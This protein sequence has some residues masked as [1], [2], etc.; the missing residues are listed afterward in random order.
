MIGG[1]LIFFVYTFSN[2]QK[3]VP[4]RWACI[5]NSITQGVGASR[6]YPGTLQ[7]FLGPA[8][9][10]QNFGV[11]ARTL[12]RKGDYSYWTQ[13]KLSEVFNF[14]PNM[15][16]IKLGTNDSKPV[17]WD[18]HKGEFEKNLSEFVDTLTSMPSKPVIWLVLPTPSFTDGTNSGDI[19]GTV[20]KNEIIPI[21]K[22]VATA[23][24]LK[25]IDVN[26]PLLNHP[27][28]FPDKVHPSDEGQD[29]IAAIFYRSFLANVTRVAC[30]GNS[31]TEYAWNG[32][33]LDAR[34]AYSIKLNELLGANY[35]V[36]NDGRSGAFMMKNG[37]SPY[38]NTG[39][40]DRALKLKPNIVTIKLGTNDSRPQNWNKNQYLADYRTMV[41]TLNKWSSKP[42]I[43]LCLPCPAWKRNGGWPFDG[44]NDSLMLAQVI[45]SIK[46]IAQEKTLDFIDLRT[47]ML[48]LESLVTD[49]VHPNAEGQDSIAHF[50]YRAF[51]KG[52]IS[53]AH[54]AANQKKPTTKNMRQLLQPNFIGLRSSDEILDHFSAQGRQLNMS[55]SQ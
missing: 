5:G 38:W 50:I 3:A 34:D 46:Q 19:R 37:P 30:I 52:P 55:I 45:P 42:K 21:I 27:E 35:W 41:D 13:G 11:S 43:F 39:L 8:F 54:Q 22:K 18:A 44:I 26:T 4:I 24:N 16:T 36:E 2:A 15:V 10:V 31:I 33:G 6:P 20:I 29:S 14:K 17:N 32:N 12:L 49:G 25:V 40:L 48:P 23:K 1:F 28:L 51:M 53:T 47:P 9:D 7:Q